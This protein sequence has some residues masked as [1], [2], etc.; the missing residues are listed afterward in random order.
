[1][2][3]RAK[4]CALVNVS[5]HQNPVYFRAWLCVT[6]AGAMPMIREPPT[7]T[8]R[9]AT[10][11]DTMRAALR[12]RIASVVG[13]SA[14]EF[15]VACC[16]ENCAPKETLSA[17]SEAA[18]QVHNTRAS[19]ARIAED[20][21][22]ATA[23]LK[24][25]SLRREHRRMRN[26]GGA[27]DERAHAAAARDTKLREYSVHAALVEFRSTPARTTS[28][29]LSGRD[30]FATNA[31]AWDTGVEIRRDRARLLIVAQL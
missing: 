8:A 27:A 31:P 24:C 2:I 7:N 16:A 11:G 15:E 14:C 23:S 6:T 28:R 26:W 25:V 17:D 5:P 30:F 18:T 20:S 29:Y 22:D 4:S 13:A 3:A 12:L 10:T 9:S 19:R 21:V 1:L